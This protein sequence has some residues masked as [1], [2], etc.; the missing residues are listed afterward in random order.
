[1]LQSARVV[2]AFARRR[3]VELIAKHYNLYNTIL[4]IL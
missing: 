4:C 3:P 1:M 2:I